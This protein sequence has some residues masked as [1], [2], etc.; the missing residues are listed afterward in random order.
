VNDAIF[1]F[2]CRN[3]STGKSVQDDVFTLSGFKNWKKVCLTN[4][5]IV[6]TYTFYII[7]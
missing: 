2:C 4:L 7:I 5:M 3:Y 6:G 1:C